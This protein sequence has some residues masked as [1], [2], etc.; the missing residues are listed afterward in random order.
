MDVTRNNIDFSIFSISLQQFLA[1]SHPQISN[2]LDFI[3]SR[4]DG[5]SEIFEVFRAN[6][7]TI[8]DAISQANTFLFLGLHFSVH[9]MLKEIIEDE[10]AE[11]IES[12][13]SWQMALELTPIVSPLMDK[14]ELGDDFK[15]S[16]EYDQFYTEAVGAILIHFN[17][18]GI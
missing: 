15:D 5:A 6:G 13:R 16:D 9:D 2:D 11:R 8:E 18:Y 10:F 17:H 14:Y 1:E 4:G 7:A 12:E 3:K